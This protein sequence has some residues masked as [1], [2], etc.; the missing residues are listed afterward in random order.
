VSNAD[1]TRI[2]VAWPEVRE[3]YNQIFLAFRDGIASTGDFKLSPYLLTSDT[4]TD[5]FLKWSTKQKVKGIVVLGNRGLSLALELQKSD[6]DKAYLPI[7]VGGTFIDG[8]TSS[9][10][11][12]AISMAP[13][14]KYLFKKFLTLSPKAD[15]VNVV[16]EPEDEWLITL[17]KE[18]AKDL[19][20]TLNSFLAQDIRQLA[21]AYQNILENQKGKTQALWLPYSGKSL[22]KA[23]MNE[24]LEIAWRRDLM[25]FSSNLAD[26]KK[27]IL[28]SLYPDNELTGRRLASLLREQLA[29][30]KNSPSES[31]LL[32]DDL[33]AALNTRTAEHLGIHISSDELN[34]YKI[35]F[36][37]KQ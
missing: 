35:L 37:L 12:S 36:P 32:S 5:D 10:G 13:S 24:V 22:E 21:A 27:G 23:L 15:T 25:V 8:N 30:S 19:N 3:P 18:A 7:V 33:F 34:K 9:L 6:Q 29:S 20:I 17:A 28:F 11:I 31:V 1:S 26:V 4:T 14:P 2:G 16:Y